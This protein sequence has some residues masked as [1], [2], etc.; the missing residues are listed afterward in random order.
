[1]LQ[2]SNV[3]LDLLEAAAWKPD[4]V[5]SLLVWLIW[6]LVAKDDLAVVLLV[7]D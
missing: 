1:M 3:M 2:D 7:P 4:F 5:G 6:K